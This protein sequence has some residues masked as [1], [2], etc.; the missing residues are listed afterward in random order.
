MCADIP[1]CNNVIEKEKQKEKN[2]MGISQHLNPTAG[3]VPGSRTIFAEFPLKN[4]FK[5]LESMSCY[6]EISNDSKKNEEK[7]LGAN[8][9]MMCL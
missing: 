2:Q 9:I 5:L 1:I 4:S 6:L 3:H 7:H 8:I